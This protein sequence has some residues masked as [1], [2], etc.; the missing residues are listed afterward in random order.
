[1]TN[2]TVSSSVTSSPANVTRNATKKEAARVAE[3][4]VEFR[5]AG[6]ASSAVSQVRRVVGQA[7]NTRTMEADD[8]V[9]AIKASY[10]R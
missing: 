4:L 8:R 7:L 9:V 2:S 10:E 3:I 1:M 5:K 6:T